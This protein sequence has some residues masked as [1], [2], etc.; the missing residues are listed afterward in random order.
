[1]ETKQRKS[2]ALYAILALL[3][4]IL[5]FFNANGKNLPTTSATGSEGFSETATNVEIKPIYN[6]EKYYIHGFEKNVTVK[7]SSANKIQLNAELN[8][9]TRN[10]SVV[11]DLSDL[12]PGTH[13]VRLRMQNLSSAVSATIDPATVTVT[14]EKKATKTFEVEPVVS[15]SNTDN[16]F[17]LGNVAVSPAEVQITTGDQTLKE[18]KRVVATVDPSKVA[19]E[20]FSET[21]AIQA[22]N[23]SGEPLS[24]QSVPDKVTI[25][26]EVVSPQ[27]VITLY[28]VQT[29]NQEE[30]I[31]YYNLTL[32]QTLATISGAQEKLDSLSSIGVP[33]DITDI[34]K[35]VRK[36]I[37]VPI[38]SGLA[39]SPKAVDVTIVPVYEAGYSRSSSDTDTST[40]TAETTTKDDSQET[41]TSSQS[42]EKNTSS[43]KE[44]ESSNRQTEE[45]N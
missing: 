44:K 33:I 13:E 10:F 29:G 21:V 30:G 2:N 19:K 40:T 18:I 16:G 4:S 35:S 42:T 15:S 34:T 11:A 14:I 41:T 20:N 25:D 23:G 32:T 22:L 28:P 27:K 1:M 7:L 8:E 5:L 17:T 36:T 6:S 45:T 3:F 38:D 24:I 43:T 31:A 26:V 9:D 39:I 12:K 37:S